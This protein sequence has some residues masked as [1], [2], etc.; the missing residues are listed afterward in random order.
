MEAVEK[1]LV[2]ERARDSVGR[3]TGAADA[4]S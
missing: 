3:P 2:E 4:R 1:G